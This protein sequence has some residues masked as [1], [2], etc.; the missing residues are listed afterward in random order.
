MA[1]LYAVLS[2]LCVFLFE[3]RER[4]GGGLA[5]LSG[6]SFAFAVLAFPYV[7]LALPVYLAYWLVKARQSRPEKRYFIGMAWFFTGAI[8]VAG[9]LFAFV[10]SRATISEVILGVKGMFSDPD[11]QN[12]NVLLILAQYFNTIR[13]MY[14]PYSYGAVAFVVLG[15]AYRLVKNARIKELLHFCGA[16]LALVLIAGITINA[17]TYDW[18]WYWRINMVAM[19]LALVAPGLYLL[20]DGKKNRAL[21]LYAVGC[22]LSIAAQIGSNTRIL[23]SSGMLLPASMATALYLFDNRE[24][25]LKV[26]IIDTL[27]T[28]LQTAQRLD[29]LLLAGAYVLVSLFVVSLCTHRIMGI[30]REESFGSLTA[31]LD[32][33][34]A[35]GIRTTPESAN[36]HHEIVKTILDNAPRS[37]NLLINYLFPEGYL[38]T[39]LRAATPS[40]YNMQLDSAWLASYYAA[41]PER[42]P[43]LVAVLHADLPFNENAGYGAEEFMSKYA[44]RPLD[45]QYLTIYR[46]AGAN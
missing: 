26:N 16:V 20:A 44:L 21:L 43:N 37:G 10:L 46:R 28:R 5:A 19:G 7:F 4:G 34:A 24:A 8:L 27:H 42:V 6:V 32:S 30:Y 2:V 31:T 18:A 13:V 25:L 39:N 17:S 9:A 23:A 15:G 14:A 35:K 11:H 29:R 41:N 22:A 1:T 33:G 40:A 12:V 36:K 45:S 38:I 3:E